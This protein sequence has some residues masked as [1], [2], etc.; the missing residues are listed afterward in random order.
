MKAVI[1][2]VKSASVTI[3]DQI[4]G[5]IQQGFMILLGIHEEDTK[6]DVDYLIRKITLMRI[7]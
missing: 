1:Q 6:E 2:R 3:D 5:S 4:V 7:F